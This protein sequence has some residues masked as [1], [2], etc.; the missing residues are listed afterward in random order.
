MKVLEITGR[1]NGDKIDPQWYSPEEIK[2]A[3]QFLSSLDRGHI[4]LS[5]AEPSI[6]GMLTANR[7]RVKLVSPDCIYYPAD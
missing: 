7:K 6:Y 3:L 4:W 2:E 5:D 1:K